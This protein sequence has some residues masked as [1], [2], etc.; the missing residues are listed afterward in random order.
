MRAAVVETVERGLQ[1]HRG[2]GE[3]EHDQRI[4]EHRQHRELHLA[5]LDLLAEIFRR[6]ADHQAGDEHRDDRD[7]QEAVEARRRRRPARCS[8]PSR[9]N[10]GTSPAS[11][12]KESN[13]ELTA[14]VLVPLVPVVNKADIAWPKR[15]SLPS[16]L[17]SDGSTPSA[18]QDRIAGGLRPV[19]D[20]DPEQGGRRA[21]AARIAQ[22]WRMI[23]RRRGRRR[24]PRRRG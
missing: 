5:H 10:I 21:I 7:D 14:P 23:A 17:P 12:V 4:D 22:P 20:E 3:A 2:A 13:I 8:R 9:L 19:D 24:A 18:G 11:G 15:T 6:A 16:K 1:Q